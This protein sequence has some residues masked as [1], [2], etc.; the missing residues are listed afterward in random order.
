MISTGIWCQHF[1]Y[2]SFLEATKPI[3]VLGT[4]YNHRDVVFR[5]QYFRNF[6]RN[7]PLLQNVPEKNL[8]LRFSGKSGEHE[9]SI[10]IS[11]IVLLYQFFLYL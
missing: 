3:F 6:Q 9:V 2:L 5:E 4:K 8:N 10:D 11:V 7:Q 1:Q